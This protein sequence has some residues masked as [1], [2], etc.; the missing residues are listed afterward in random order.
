MTTAVH[1]GL[2][3]LYHPGEAWIAY[4]AFRD[5][6]IQA[7]PDEVSLCVLTVTPLT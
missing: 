1:A 7:S 2:E 6:K 4:F 3:I 5:M